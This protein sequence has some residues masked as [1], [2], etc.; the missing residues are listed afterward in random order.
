MMHLTAVVSKI[1]LPAY[2]LLPAKLHTPEADV[3]L[4]TIGLQESRFIY[5]HQIGGPAH[6][7]WQGEQGGG[8][9]A[10]VRT[11]A[12]T[13]DMAAKVYAARNV[14]ATI[15]AIYEA[16]EHDDVLAAALARL[17][18]YSDPKPLPKIGDIDGAWGLYLRTWRPGKPKPDSWP[19]HYAN[20]RATLGV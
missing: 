13:K 20:A 10:G 12:A 11:H 17:L 1:L 8:M 4:L 18:L 6:S 9:V 14:P 7:F 3:M 5:R 16:I 19:A 2:A 15:E